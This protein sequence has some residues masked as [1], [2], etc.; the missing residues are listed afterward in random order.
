MSDRLFVT[1]IGAGAPTLLLLHGMSGNGELWRPLMEEA[2]GEWPGRIVAPDLRGHG[3]SFHASHYGYGHQ[4][5]DVAALLAPGEEVAVLG[6]SMG[7]LVGL[8]LATG[9]YGLA[10]TSLFGFSVKTDWTEEELAR[11][12]NLGRSPARWFKTRDEAVERFLRVAG[13]AGL[14]AADHPACE[15]GVAQGDGGYRLAADN[16]T[17]LAAGPDIRTM[18]SAAGGLPVVLACGA[19]DQMVS[20]QQLRSLGCK[21][22][23]M[24]DA[25]HNPHVEQPKRLWERARAHLLRPKATG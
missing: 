15:A 11:A 19:R 2:T 25:G 3:R 4:A 1:E 18:L 24:P 13:V 6:H 14:L 21:A 9:W 17:A 16:A 22:I 12:G 23:E 10:V 20:I 7:V 8:A 5:A